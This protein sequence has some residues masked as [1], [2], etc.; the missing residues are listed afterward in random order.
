MSEQAGVA[1]IVTLAALVLLTAVVLAFFSLTLI[2]RQISFSSSGQNRAEILA[3]TAMDTTIADL[4]SEMQ[5]GST[6]LYGTSFGG[7]TTNGVTIYVPFTNFTAVPCRT[8]SSSL[9][10]LITESLGGTNFWFGNYYNPAAAVPQRASSDT[11]YSTLSPSLN[12]RYIP[13]NIWSKPDLLTSTNPTPSWIMITC[14]GPITNASA[15]TM[16]S[17][18]TM[19]NSA[20][21]N[22]NYVIGRYA[23]A[24][25]DE[26]GLVDV[27]VAGNALNATNNAQRGRLTEAA[28]GQLPLADSTPGDSANT[29]AA[30][31]LI[32]WRSPVGSTNS[33]SWIF[34]PT[35]TFTTL[36][37]TND[38]AF[39]S[40]QDLINYFANTAGFQTNALPFITTFS[41]ELDAPG[42]TPDPNRAKVQTYT[43]SYI[44][45]YGIPTG[46]TSTSWT[47][48]SGGGT[49]VSQPISFG[50]GNPGTYGLDNT[51]NP[52]LVNF[53]GSDGNP[54]MKERFPLSRL[55][56]LTF[57]GPIADAN[58]NLNPNGDSGVAAEITAYENA[59]IPASY[60]QQGT[61][62]NILAYFGLV[63]DPVATNNQW[64]YVSPEGSLTSPVATT[65]IKTLSA[66]P[67]TRL[68]G[69][70]FFETLQA[71]ILVGSLGRDAGPAGVKDGSWAG[72]YARY[73]NASGVESDVI[74]EDQNVYRHVLQIGANIIDQF[75]PDSYPTAIMMGV[76]TST[77]TTVFG[78]ENLPY[79]SRMNSFGVQ[80]YSANL[81]RCFLGAEVWNP[82]QAALTVAPSA[83]AAPTTLRII[84]VADPDNP[85]S[86]YSTPGHCYVVVA[87]ATGSS[88]SV[89]ASVNDILNESLQFSNSSSLSVPTL[90]TSL[91]STLGGSMTAY[92]NAAPTAPGVTLYGLTAGT[93]STVTGTVNGYTASKP[94]S[95]QFYTVNP[96]IYPGSSLNSFAL[97]YQKSGNW[98]PYSVVRNVAWRSAPRYAF[99]SIPKSQYYVTGVNSDG[100][101]NGDSW[102]DIHIDPRTD[103]FGM[104]GRVGEY[105]LVNQNPFTSQA[106]WYS[107]SYPAPNATASTPNNAT[108]ENDYMPFLFIASSAAAGTPATAVTVSKSSAFV[109][110]TTKIGDNTLNTA[111]AGNNCI[112]LFGTSAATGYGRYMETIADN[113]GPPYATGGTAVSLNYYQD[114]DGVVRPGVGAYTTQSQSVGDGRPMAMNSGQTAMLGTSQPMILNRPFRSVAELGYTF[115]D[116]PWKDIDFFSTVSGDAALLEAFSID[117]PTTLPPLGVSAKTFATTNSTP[118]TSGTGKYPFVAGKLDLNTQ[119]T[120]ALQAMLYGAIRDDTTLTGTDATISQADTT[121]IAQALVS[122]TTSNST[123]SGPLQSKADLVTNFSGDLINPSVY[124][125]SSADA[126]I[127]RRREAA[128]RAL[129]DAGNVRTWNLLIDIIAQAGKYTS[130][131]ITGD[132]FIVDGERHYWLHVALDR[133]TGKIIDY[134]LE[135]VYD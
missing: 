94:V 95:G 93:I 116:E 16:P 72:N 126:V 34:N 10:N 73:A 33:A 49:S 62:A 76:T 88:A 61:P 42:Y 50:V 68:T 26:G 79:V 105:G 22:P 69:P 48:P 100:P 77:Y 17:I 24:I 13:G 104:M 6:N 35:N 134:Y 52:S 11:H 120:T 99:A 127:K 1:L 106:L 81:M 123:G 80:D 56:W 8:V 66:I 125:Y 122:R 15:A 3:R 36:A 47:G 2:H 12:G 63:W 37:S 20:V 132:Q 64:I 4:V 40:R 83:L 113:L 109:Q 51:F 124:T 103:R 85:A 23:Y 32:A 7:S 60:L 133:L 96:V 92:C 53:R 18:A 14:Q 118:Y 59:G 70:D 44:Y 98:Y 108:G 45:N 110:Q 65:T 114:P 129:A 97:E 89:G 27:N 31:N 87:T 58:G 30:A 121:A 128:I 38:Q 111:A 57:L 25:Y 71:A 119:N 29:T 46:A 84:A 75:D 86:S 21:S 135:P 5:A 131:S 78:T 67:S 101:W 117:D 102:G 54:L 91:N 115:R 28:L 74:A 82:H 19:A 9:T 55:A 107:A 112:T 90:L 41:R 39:V 130:T 43:G